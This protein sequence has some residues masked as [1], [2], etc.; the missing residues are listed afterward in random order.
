LT[1]EGYRHVPRTVSADDKFVAVIGPDRKRYLYPLE[2]G[3]PQ[4]IPGLAPGET[5]AGWT[6]DGRFLYIVRRRDVP[7]RVS[8][9]DIATGEKEPWKE[10]MPGDGA[11]IQDISPVIP[12]PDGQSY[13][14]GYARTLSDMYVV[15]GMK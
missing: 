12:T 15:E 8:K 6:A 3:E 4:A 14:Y 11:G 10:F 9:L 2:G 1:P 7:A 5:P 13:V